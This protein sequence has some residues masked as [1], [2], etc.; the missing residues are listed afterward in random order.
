MSLGRTVRVACILV[1]AMAVGCGIPARLEQASWN[2]DTRAIGVRCGEGNEEACA[3]LADRALNH[4]SAAAR[5]SAVVD[6][7][8]RDEEVLAQVARQEEAWGTRLAALLRLRDDQELM[9]EIAKTDRDGRVSRRAALLVKDVAL[10]EDVARNAWHP[11]AREAAIFHEGLDN[12]ELLARLATN[13]VEVRVRLAAAAKAVDQE[14]AQQVFEEIAATGQGVE[15][16]RAILA[17]TD[18]AVLTGIALSG[19]HAA[20]RGRA[21]GRLEDR[22]VLAKIAKEDEDEAVRKRARER[23][24]ELDKGDE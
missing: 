15:Q 17:L 20:S 8:L 7:D 13:D 16:S 18:Q 14:L 4:A 22:Q 24:Q 11:N 6:P 1:A 12:Q 3:K 10:A 9:A 5:H 21:V 2:R 23:L 19:E